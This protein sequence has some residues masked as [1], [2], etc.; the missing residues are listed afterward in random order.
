MYRVKIDFRAS[1]GRYYYI[2]NE[3]GELEYKRLQQTEKRHLEKITIPS[4]PFI[5]ENFIG[6]VELNKEN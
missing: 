5:P 2:G 1:N 3:V 4:I 6:G